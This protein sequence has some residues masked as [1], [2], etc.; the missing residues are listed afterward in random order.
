[1]G[2]AARC[3][4]QQAIQTRISI[5]VTPF[6]DATARGARNLLS[7]IL[8][9][10]VHAHEVDYNPAERRKITPAA[11]RLHPT[12]KGTRRPVYTPP[13]HGPACR[14][15]RATA[16]TRHPAWPKAP[17]SHHPLFQ[18]RWVRYKAATS[19]EQRSQL[20]FMSGWTAAEG[21]TSCSFARPV[22]G[23]LVTERSAAR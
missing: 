8:A 20:S 14:S 2:R 18:M 7:T 17:V 3:R 11:E 22:S 5:R 9:D 4:A 10:A 21:T 15:A 13:S 19:S 12:R 1:M 23:T 16:R 6:A